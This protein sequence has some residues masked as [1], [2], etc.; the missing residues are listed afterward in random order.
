MINTYLAV[1][2]VR[3]LYTPESTIH[4]FENGAHREGDGFGV[5]IGVTARV[6]KG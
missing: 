3:I 4:R 6:T 5:L 2:N 1:P